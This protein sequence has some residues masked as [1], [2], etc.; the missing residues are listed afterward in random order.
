MDNE[1]V[2]I[3]VAVT[4]EGLDLAILP[5]GIC[6][7]DADEDIESVVMRLAAEKPDLIVI[8][9]ADGLEVPLA[10]LAQV[11]GL[12]VAVVEPQQVRGFART[13]AL[14]IDGDRPDALTLARFASIAHPEPQFLGGGCDP[15]LDGLLERWRQLVAMRTLEKTRL[16]LATPLQKQSIREHLEWLSQNIRNVD[17]ALVEAWHAAI[18]ETI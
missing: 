14:T 6:V 18:R 4:F 10:L 11:A 7:H 16:K 1:A 8:G 17:H 15:V 13:M 3:G 5:A 2:F 9:A 12:P